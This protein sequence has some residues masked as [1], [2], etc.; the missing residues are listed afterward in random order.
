MT[1]S[2]AGSSIAR[3]PPNP[4]SNSFNVA[5]TLPDWEHG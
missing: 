3:R 2:R 4:L 1:R 5:L